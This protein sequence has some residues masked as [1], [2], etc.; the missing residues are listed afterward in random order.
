MPTSPRAVAPS[1]RRRPAACSPRTASLSTST[2]TPSRAPTASPSRSGAALTASRHGLL[3]RGTAPTVRCAPVHQRH[4][5]RTISVKRHEAALA[6]ARA[7]QP[8]PDWRADY[9][10]TRPKVERKLGHLMRRRHGGRR[11]RVRGTTQSRRR[12]QSP[13]RRRQPGPP[14]RPR[15]ALHPDRMGHRRMNRTARAVPT[16]ASVPPSQPSDTPRSP[17]A[18]NEEPPTTPTQA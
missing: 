1:H 10:A 15:P 18:L 16:R 17:A 4:D 11:A 6:K 13:R 12:L 8:D 7:R 2:P 5:G 9:R 3:R 14:R